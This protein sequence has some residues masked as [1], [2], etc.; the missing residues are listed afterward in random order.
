[1]VFHVRNDFSQ[2]LDVRRLQVNHVIGYNAVVQVP[3]VDPQVIRGQEV[4]AVAT[5][6]D[7]VDVVVV[8]VF[9]LLSLDALVASADYLRL[10]KLNLISID[11]ALRLQLS[12]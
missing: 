7:G 1:M 5:D 8:A 2:F 6:A 11:L 10:G 12:V 4:L 9:V 3:Q